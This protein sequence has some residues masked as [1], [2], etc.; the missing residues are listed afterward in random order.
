MKKQYFLPAYGALTLLL[1]LVCLLAAACEEDGYQPMP[2]T[3][4][5]PGELTFT[6]NVPSRLTDVPYIVEWDVDEDGVTVEPDEDASVSDVHD[7]DCIITETT[8]FY[9]KH[10]AN[11]TS[12]KITVTVTKLIDDEDDMGVLIKDPGFTPIVDSATFTVNSASGD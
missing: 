1:V 12:F 7:T 4:F 9:T 2:H 10:A 6:V 5:D 3:T 11:I 8:V